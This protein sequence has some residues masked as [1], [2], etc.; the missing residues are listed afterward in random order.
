MTSYQ[1]I[2]LRASSENY[3]A[4]NPEPLLPR[5]FFNPQII[6]NSNRLVFNASSDSI[7]ASAQ[8]TISLTSNNLRGLPPNR[9]FSFWIS[10][11]S[12]FISSVEAIGVNGFVINITNYNLF[13]LYMLYLLRQ[14]LGC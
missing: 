3:S 13:Y 12:L 1:Q 14:M 11:L 6:L 5:E 10:S 7:L 8:D 4:L 9:L 2:P